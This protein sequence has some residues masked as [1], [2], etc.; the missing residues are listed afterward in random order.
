MQ[1]FALSFT[2]TVDFARLLLCLL[3]GW[4]AGCVFAM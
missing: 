4:L 2:S 3:A 1:S